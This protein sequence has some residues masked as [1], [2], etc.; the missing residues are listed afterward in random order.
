MQTHL[1]PLWKERLL[2]VINAR[3]ALAG[4]PPHESMRFLEAQAR[5]EGGNARWNP[6]NSSVAIKQDGWHW[7]T[8]PDY[9]SIPVRNYDTQLHGVLAMAATLFDGNFNGIAGFLQNPQITAEE[10]CDKYAAQIHTWG[11]DP[12]LMKRVL[13]NIP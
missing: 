8:T 1:P 13:A 4:D 3:G 6:L 7:N 5:A 12:D 11:T 10:A 2:A 9:N